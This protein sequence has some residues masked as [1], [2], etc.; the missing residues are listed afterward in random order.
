MCLIKYLSFKNKYL[1]L[2]ESTLWQKVNPAECALIKL[3]G[4]VRGSRRPISWVS[5]LR[6]CCSVAKVGDEPRQQKNYFK[7]PLMYAL[8]LTD[9][10]CCFSTIHNQLENSTCENIW[11]VSKDVIGCTWLNPGPLDCR[12]ECLTTSIPYASCFYHGP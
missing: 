8:N 3:T 4:S 5:D 11:F 12:E 6:Y 2:S 10:W 9:P 7:Q 1:S